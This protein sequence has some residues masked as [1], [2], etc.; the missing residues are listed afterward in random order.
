MA[1]LVSVPCP[2]HE[3]VPVH[4]AEALVQ[5]PCLVA[6]ARGYSVRPISSGWSDQSCYLAFSLNGLLEGSYVKW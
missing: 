4:V 5:I 2:V 3:L 1:K 6:L